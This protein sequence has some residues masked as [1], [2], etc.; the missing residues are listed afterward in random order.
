MANVN[1]AKVSGS[2]LW[3]PLIHPTQI[4]DEPTVIPDLLIQL[5]LCIQ[6]VSYNLFYSNVTKNL[7]STAWP[8]G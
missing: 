5:K 4:Q 3:L 6:F 8:T 1:S 2:R 7:S